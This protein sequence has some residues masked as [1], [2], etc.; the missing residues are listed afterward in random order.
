MWKE[1]KCGID[2]DNCYVGDSESYDEGG[3]NSKTWPRF[4]Y[5]GSQSNE[6]LILAFCG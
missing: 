5:W 2:T 1:K 4:F 3:E 6:P